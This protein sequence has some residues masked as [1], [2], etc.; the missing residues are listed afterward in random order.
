MRRRCRRPSADRDGSREGLRVLGSA[1]PGLTWRNGSDGHAHAPE[2]HLAS[3]APQRLAQLRDRDRDRP[4]ASGAHGIRRDRQLPRRRDRHPHPGR[5]PLARAGG[6]DLRA[7][8]ERRPDA[9]QHRGGSAGNG[10]SVR[11]RVPGEPSPAGRQPSLRPGLLC[12][13][14][15]GEPRSGQRSAEGRQAWRLGLLPGLHVRSLSPAVGRRPLREPNGTSLVDTGDA[16]PDRLRRAVRR[17]RRR[18]GGAALSQRFLQRP[19]AWPRGGDRVVRHPRRRPAR[20]AQ[21]GDRSGRL[22]APALCRVRRPPADRGRLYRARHR[23]PHED[24]RLSQDPRIPARRR[25]GREHRERARA[26]ASHGVAAVP[27]G[28]Q[29]VRPRLRAH[30]RD[31]PARA[32]TRRGR[33][34]RASDPEA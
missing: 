23:R 25:R 12:H 17:R 21:P 2:T 32:G 20:R 6:A 30:L 13:R 34:A 19:G 16:T 11:S 10:P 28:R 33:R 24:H 8:Q 4:C 26:L 27:G 14:R 15:Q 7:V 18:V 29:P 9:A 1:T 5:Q 31:Q 22:H 3:P